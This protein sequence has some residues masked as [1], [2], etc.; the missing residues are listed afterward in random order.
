MNV[1]EERGYDE[2]RDYNP[3]GEGL[4]HCARNIQACVQTADISMGCWE[5]HFPMNFVMMIHCTGDWFND[6]SR[7]SS[8]PS[9]LF[10]V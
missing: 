10:E 4:G 6:V 8:T 2:V 1:T 7:T 3:T 9:R 5:L